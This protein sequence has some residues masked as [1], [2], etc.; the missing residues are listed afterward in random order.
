MSDD[1]DMLTVADY[2]LLYMEGSIPLES[3]EEAV[4]AERRRISGEPRRR[5]LP[6]VIP[7]QGHLFTTTELRQLGWSEDKIDKLRALRR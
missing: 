4:K 5:Q 7:K 6:A 1:I 2:A 3:L